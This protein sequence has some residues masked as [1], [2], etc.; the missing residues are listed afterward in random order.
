V[1]IFIFQFFSEAR[2]VKKRRDFYL[3][4]PYRIC[5]TETANAN[6]AALQTIIFD[7]LTR[8]PYA[9]YGRKTASCHQKNVKFITFFK[10]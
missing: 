6:Y 2:A 3:S 9:H 4:A 1:R 8:T 5:V 7:V 10:V